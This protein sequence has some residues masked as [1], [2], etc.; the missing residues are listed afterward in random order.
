MLSLA[1]AALGYELI[2]D[3][4]G[5][6][7]FDGWD[8]YG[9]WDNLTLGNVTYLTQEAATQQKLTY[10]NDAGNAIIKVDN[11]TTVASGERRNSI[12]LTSQEYYDFG[13]VWII[14]ALHMPWGCSVWPAFW[15]TAP[16]WPVG[17]EIDI[18]EGINTQPNNQFAIH[19]TEGCYHDNPPNQAGF[20]IDTNCSQA[21]GCTVGINTQN[22][23]QAG[24]AAAG[25]GVY[26]TQYDTSGIYMWFWSRPNVPASLSS[27]STSINISDWGTPTASFP[28]DQACNTTKFFK[29]Q[30]LIFDITLCGDWAGVPGIYDSE[31]YNAGPHHDCYLDNVVG[32]GSNYDD[33]YFEVSYVRT[34]A[35]G[36]ALAAA[37]ASKTATT[38]STASTSSAT[39]SHTQTSDASLPRVSLHGVLFMSMC[40]AGLIAGSVLPLL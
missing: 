20:N 12:R 34:Y 1:S 39:Q 21:S 14:D 9:K 13:T 35:T 22:S 6:T 8:Y 10:V 24:F 3:Y 15:S 38:S 17:G 7:F 16:D 33:A 36:A 28:N 11:F 2:H 29:P 27:S 18:V 5:N 37:Q 19:T 26:A 23:Y 40:V 4:S 25:G 31:C 30:Q 32:N